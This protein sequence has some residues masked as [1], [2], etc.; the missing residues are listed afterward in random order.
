[1]KT[2]SVHTERRGEKVHVKL[3]GEFDLDGAREVEEELKEVE[4]GRPPL[5]V[6]D[7]SELAFVDSTGMRVI[8]SAS[9]R[10]KKDSRRFVIVRG[11]DTVQRIF[12]ITRLDERL[13][14]V[15]SAEDL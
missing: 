7:L 8:L 2:F 13:D 1:M 5:L 14:M 11:R 15:D 6:L 12:E 3:I 10:A 9:K 4:Q